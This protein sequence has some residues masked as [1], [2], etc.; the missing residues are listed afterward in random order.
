M[1]LSLSTLPTLVQEIEQF[2]T[3]EQLRGFLCEFTEQLQFKYFWYML[4]EKCYLSDEK[5]YI[6]CNYPKD[7]LK[8][9][10][11]R[12]RYRN[13]PVWCYAYD[14]PQQLFHW[15]ELYEH[16]KLAAAYRQQLAWC[17]RFDIK[18]G[19]A[20]PIH[21]PNN[22]YGVL[23]FVLNGDNSLV[24]DQLVEIKPLFLLLSQLIHQK[25]KVMKSNQP[26]NT[27]KLTARETESLLWSA[28]GKTAWEISKIMSISEY[29][30]KE[31]LTHCAQKLNANN[32]AAT[33]A[34][35]LMNGDILFMDIAT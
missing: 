35:A 21:G 22:E 16:E 26:S 20:C 12:N 14:K 13:D 7:F 25:V 4:Y 17:S 18:D 19:L 32:K 10:A 15:N 31:H 11:E 24:S 34:R 28:K 9:Y 2:T 3:A 8:S 33:I 29:T 1:K 27:A 30:V 5:P 6:L 23:Y